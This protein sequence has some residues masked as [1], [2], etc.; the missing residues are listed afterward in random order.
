MKQLLVA[1]VLI[2]GLLSS[3]AVFSQYKQKDYKHA[4][5]MEMMKDSTMMKQ[6]MEHIASDY[7]MRKMM[8]MQMMS[9]VKSDSSK[10]MDMCKMMMED[11]EMHGM[12]KKMMGGGMMGNGMMKNDM[13]TTEKAAPKIIVK[14]KPETEES[15][16]KNMEMESGLEKIKEIPELNMKVYR[17]TSTKSVEEVIEACQKHPFVEYAE[18]DQEYRTM[19]RKS[20]GEKKD[21]HQEHHQN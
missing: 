8:M 3:S 13:Q 9:S 7:H 1:L 4:Q 16:I 17:I 6:M 14:F 15:Q 11:R 20:T 18:A 2:G 12:M 5:M 21:D 19:E 10:M